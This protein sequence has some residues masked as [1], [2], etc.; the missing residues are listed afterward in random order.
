[1]ANWTLSLA[2]PRCAASNTVG[3]TTANPA[4]MARPDTTPDHPRTRR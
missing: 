4:M 2:S 1:M 3:S